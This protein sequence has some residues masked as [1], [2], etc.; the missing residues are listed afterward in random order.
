MDHTRCI[1]YF[2]HSKWL[3]YSFVVYS[4]YILQ[5]NSIGNSY[6]FEV[7]GYFTVLKYTAIL[8]ILFTWHGANEWVVCVVFPSVVDERGCGGVGRL[9]V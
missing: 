6:S 3:F 4:Y 8:K 9:V 1:Y 7:Y 2:T 5:N